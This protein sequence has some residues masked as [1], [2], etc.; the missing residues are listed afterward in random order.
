MKKKLR[1]WIHRGFAR[2][3][4]VMERWIS[5]QAREYPELAALRVLDLGC[6]AGVLAGAFDPVRYRGIDS[7]PTAVAAGNQ[8]MISGW[9]TCAPWRRP[10]CFGS[11]IPA[12]LSLS[13]VPG[14]QQRVPVYP[15]SVR[16]GEGE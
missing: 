14:V 7:D 5:L 10:R 3:R 13:V 8:I 6:G 16:D 9:P 4:A 15:G 11:R 1:E 2:E 12:A